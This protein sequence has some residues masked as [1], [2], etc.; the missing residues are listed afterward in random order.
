MKENSS[1]LHN[2]IK[3]LDRLKEGLLQYNEENELLL[4]KKGLID[5]CAK[6]QFA[7]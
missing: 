5:H 1:K 7:F 4:A 3:A 2:F 6:S